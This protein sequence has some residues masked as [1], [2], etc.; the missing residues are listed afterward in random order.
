MSAQR[1]ILDLELNGF[2]ESARR[3]IKQLNNERDKDKLCWVT[4]S[5]LKLGALGT[6]TSG[7]C[8]GFR[9]GTSSP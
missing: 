4:H 1:F 6:W 5:V 2:V 7:K 9:S 3:D 8:T